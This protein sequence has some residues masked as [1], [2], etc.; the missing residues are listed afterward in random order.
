MKPLATGAG[1]CLATGAGRPVDA[2]AAID[3]GSQPRSTDGSLDSGP[4]RPHPRFT[5][6]GFLETACEE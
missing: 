6:K 4:G 3:P 2:K 5:K 1:R